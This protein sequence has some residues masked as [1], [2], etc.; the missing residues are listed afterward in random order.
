M[1]LMEP[2][3]LAVEICAGRYLVP[4]TPVWAAGRDSAALGAVFVVMV[5]SSCCYK[6]VAAPDRLSFATSLVGTSNDCL[7]SRHHNE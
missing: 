5:A 6:T 3:I 2:D 7:H 4:R 1:V